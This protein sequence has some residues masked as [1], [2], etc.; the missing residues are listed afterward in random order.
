M[1]NQT[2]ESLKTSVVIPPPTAL[3]RVIKDLFHQGILPLY[4]VM[5]IDA[6]IRPMFMV[7][8]IQACF[9][10]TNINYHG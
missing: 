5:D 8:W 2:S 10:V 6:C 3:D 1:E 4:S 9:C 7:K